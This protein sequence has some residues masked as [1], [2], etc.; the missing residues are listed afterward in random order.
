MNDSQELGKDYTLVYKD[1]LQS[2][3]AVHHCKGGYILSE[4]RC[5]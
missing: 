3:A 1:N 4:G 5:R 2:V